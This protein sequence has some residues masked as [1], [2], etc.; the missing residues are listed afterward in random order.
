MKWP[1]RNKKR[2]IWLFVI[3]LAWLVILACTLIVTVT[4]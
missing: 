4:M 2:D 3:S 1:V